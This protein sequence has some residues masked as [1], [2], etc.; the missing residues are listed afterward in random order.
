MSRK[1]LTAWLCETAEISIMLVLKSGGQCAD[2]LSTLNKLQTTYSQASTP[3]NISKYSAHHARR[4]ATYAM[5]SQLHV[6]NI[7]LGQAVE[8]FVFCHT[9][10]TTTKHF[11][12][13][14]RSSFLNKER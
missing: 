3:Q 6:Y 11:A 5:Q 12:M 8:Q 4:T 7:S 2:V 10:L 14:M 9:G 13:F 1:H